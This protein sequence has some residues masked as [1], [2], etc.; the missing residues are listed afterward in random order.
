MPAGGD[1]KNLVLLASDGTKVT[2]PKADVEEQKASTLSVMPEGLLDPL[3]L[4]EIADLLAL[5]ESAPKV[6]IPAAPPPLK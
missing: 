4:Q 6:E 2:I 1:E 5:F 3:T